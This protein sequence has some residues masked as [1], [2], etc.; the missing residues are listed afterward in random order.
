AL[1]ARDAIAAF[2]TQASHE[3]VR[4]DALLAQLTR[5]ANDHV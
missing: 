1:R 2:C 5:L 4:F 3:D